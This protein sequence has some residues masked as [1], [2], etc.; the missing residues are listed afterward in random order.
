MAID[1]K[2]IEKL[3]ATGNQARIS[4]MSN[5]DEQALEVAALYPEWTS[6]ADGSQLVKGERVNYNGVLYNVL[7][8]HEK[9]ESWSPDASPSLFA[10]VLIPDP[11]VIPDWEQPDSTNP[12]K[13]GDRVKHN[14]KVWESLTDGNVW[15][16]GA[17]GSESL[18]KE[19]V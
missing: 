19:V 2:T 17:G 13:K 14:G 15:E 8:D 6:L 7:S 5:T 4:A 1:R 18:W 10:K 9:Q 16:P 3:M 11:S 12:Y